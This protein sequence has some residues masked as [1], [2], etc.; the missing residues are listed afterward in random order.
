[1]PSNPSQFLPEPAPIADLDRGGRINRTWLMAFFQPV[2][3][4][5]VS[6][7]NVFGLSSSTD[8]TIALF[9]GTTGKQLKEA[10]GTGL[11]TATNGV[12]STLTLA[13]SKLLGR[14]SAA[15]TGTP[16]EITLG[17]NLTMSGT[18]L[19]ASAGTGTVTHTGA[20]T[21]N[22]LVVGNGTDDIKVVAATNGQIPIG[23]TS[24]GS[25]TLASITAGTGIS[26]TPGAASLTIAT[27]GGAGG[28]GNSIYSTAFGSEPGS[29]NTGDA[30]LYTNS[31]YLSRY[32]GSAWVPWGP[33]Y[34]CVQPINADY[35]WVNQGTAS[36][37]TTN[38][39]IFLLGPATAG[40]NLR[41]RDK[42]AP[43]TPYTITGLF[44]P[45]FVAADYHQ[46]GLLFR[47][48]GSG[49]V[50]TFGLIHETGSWRLAVTRWNSA[51]SH[52]SNVHQLDIDDI[53]R[54]LMLQIED[55]GTD[56]FY[57]WSTDG[58][59]WLQVY[60]EANN[61]F[62]TSNRVGFFVNDQTNARDVATLLMS[63]AEA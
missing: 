35:S 25:V 27:S 53:P 39:G 23:K 59:H 57:R 34:P 18:T 24:D 58:Q 16:V 14:G 43:S 45:R 10:S 7:G 21:A 9:D 38:G 56:F 44:L 28:S 55:D 26:I 54:P 1:M 11:V 46:C 51:T 47:E 29:P 60:T 13:A 8:G 37:D 50:I 17:T 61:L 5:L 22:Q 31:V 40:V 33:I 15:G 3:K 19:N 63:W 12:Y 4:I 32:S 52:N 20:L 62:L 42:A 6:V 49:E 48:S 2:A 30:D 36:V 41:I